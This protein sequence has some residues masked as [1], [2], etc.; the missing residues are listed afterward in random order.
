MNLSAKTL[1]K[2]DTVIPKYPQKR[3]AVMTLLHYIQA[4]AGYISSE[5]VEWVAEK[6]EVQPVNVLEMVTFFPYYRQE[7]LG[8]VHVRVCRTLSCALMGA[9]KLGDDLAKK[10]DCKM[11]YT[12]DDGSVT[13]EYAECLAACGTG[14]VVLVDEDLYENLN[15]TGSVQPMVEEINRRIGLEVPVVE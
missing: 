2:I 6:L 5:A 10:L 15:R 9:Y 8:K 7:K 12:K 13:L 14:P 11:G 4:E 1:E 3:S